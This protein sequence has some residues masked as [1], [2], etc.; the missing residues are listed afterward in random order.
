MDVIK[1]MRSLHHSI[2]DVIDYEHI[3]IKN[4]F[5]RL[6]E[7]VEIEVLTRLSSEDKIDSA[8]C[9]HIYNIEGITPTVASKEIAKLLPAAVTRLRSSFTNAG[10]QASEGDM[11]IAYIARVKERVEREN[12][13]SKTSS[14][15]SSGKAFPTALPVVPPVVPPVTAKAIDRERY[16]GS[17]EIT[18]EKIRDFFLASNQK[19]E[20]LQFLLKYCELNHLID[21]MILP[22]EILGR[23]I[24]SATQ[25]V[26]AEDCT[27]R[28][29]IPDEVTGAFW[30]LFGIA[31]PCE[32]QNTYAECGLD[33]EHGNMILASVLN[34]IGAEL[35]SFKKSSPIST[36]EAA[37]SEESI[38]IP[39]PSPVSSS[40]LS[41][42]EVFKAAKKCSKPNP[43][44]SQ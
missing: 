18:P 2:V 1:L 33:Q 23:I 15:S 12:A 31:L 25:R 3:M 35:V 17:V 34:E 14:R 39:D 27:R 13:P 37:F 19:P 11:F 24:V 28:M 8:A 16:G 44:K 43:T 32:V 26:T 9:G 41:K 40:P 30:L 36:R 10:F 5:E 38:E 21:P 22:P 42:P 20:F 29:S 6:A 7:W 4:D